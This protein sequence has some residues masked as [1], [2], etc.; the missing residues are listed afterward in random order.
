MSLLNKIE[1]SGNLTKDPEIE[2]TKGGTKTAK[3]DIAHNYKVKDETRVDYFQVQAYGAVAEFIE[4][5]LK[6]GE[7][8]AVFGEMHIN[9]SDK[10][11]YPQIIANT[12]LQLHRKEKAESEE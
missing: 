11:Q 5:N 9:I 2:E 1:I 3:F 10:K 12:V 4:K 8:V 7:P 6:K